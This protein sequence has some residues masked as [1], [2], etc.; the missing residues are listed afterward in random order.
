MQ[1]VSDAPLLG[2]WKVALELPKAAES[3]TLGRRQEHGRSI[4]VPWVLAWQQLSGSV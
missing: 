2:R 1:I 3:C 4:E